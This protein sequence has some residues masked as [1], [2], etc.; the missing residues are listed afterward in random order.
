MLSP[1]LGGLEQSLLDY[2][3]ALTIEGHA[4]HA[5]VHP[6]WAAR[7]ALERLPL[8]RITPLANYNEWD[9]IAVRRLHGWLRAQAPDVVL[10]IGRRASVLTRRARRRLPRLVQVGVTPNYSLGPLI[11]LDHV[12]ATTSDLRQ[13]LIG[14]G[15]PP[16]RIT[17]V[18]N[19]VRVPTEVALPRSDP[20]AL[21]VIG[22]LG[23]LVAR[24]GFADL[25]EALA[26]LQERGYL[27]E[28]IG[29][30]HV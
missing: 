29:R 30:A 28:E 5:L 18:P 7:P 26:L 11:G 20:T 4:V 17:V 21:P 6:R 10:T 25:I 13:A 24:K 23:R 15:Q 8:R 14:A 12:L 22:A 9:P 1:G 2:C 19:L 3:E 27:F 16:E